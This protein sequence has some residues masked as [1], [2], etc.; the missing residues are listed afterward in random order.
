MS[1]LVFQLQ[2][3]I[4][5]LGPGGPGKPIPGRPGSPLD[6]GKPGNPGCPGGPGLPVQIWNQFLLNLLHMHLRPLNEC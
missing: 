3:N 1:Q 2:E 4:V 5:P 6:P